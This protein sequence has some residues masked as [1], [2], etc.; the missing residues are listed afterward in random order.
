MLVP[1]LLFSRSNT[2]QK[3]L[4]TKSVLLASIVRHWYVEVGNI[5]VGMGMVWD[6]F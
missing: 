6:G 3:D 4:C 1:K 5:F 2:R